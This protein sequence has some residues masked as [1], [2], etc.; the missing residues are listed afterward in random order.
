M[1]YLPVASNIIPF[2]PSLFHS[3][4]WHDSS[5]QIRH[6]FM[7]AFLFSLCQSWFQE[8]LKFCNLVNK[9]NISK[10]VARVWEMTRLLEFVLPRYDNTRGQLAPGSGAS[11]CDEWGTTNR[12]WDLHGEHTVT[13]EEEAGEPASWPHSTLWPSYLH[14]LFM[15][16]L[17]SHIQLDVRFW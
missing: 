15:N 16:S 14:S 13:H 11:S 12:S 5:S 2:L 8:R 6:H 10:G 4:R 17:T 9:K 7:Q 1:S 3:M